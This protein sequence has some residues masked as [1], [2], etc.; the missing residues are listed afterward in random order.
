MTKPSVKG[1]NI[2]LHPFP[3]APPPELTAIQ[4]KLAMLGTA[5]AAGLAL[6]WF[7]TALGHGFW[8]FFR[9]T[10]VCGAVGAALVTLV[11]LISRGL[12]KEMERV[13]AIRSRSLARPPC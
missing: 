12:E 4:R 13:R 11:S 10:A 8:R 3:P 6:V 7:F 5:C 1:T 2:L 9:V